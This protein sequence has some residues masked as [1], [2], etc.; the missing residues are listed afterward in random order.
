[1]NNKI[2]INFIQK[3]TLFVF[4]FLY[5]FFLLA[6]EPNHVFYTNPKA[7]SEYNSI[8]TNIHFSLSAPVVDENM[9][10]KFKITN[11][12]NEQIFF[13]SYVFYYGKFLVL[14]PLTKLPNHQKIKVA[15]T[16]K[17][18][19]SGGLWVDP[20][21]YTFTTNT[22]DSFE[23]IRMKVLA[24]D[25]SAAANLRPFV[26]ESKQA[27]YT[28]TSTIPDETPM[29][30]V[31]KKTNP[32]P[33]QIMLTTLTTSGTQQTN[34]LLIVD[35]DG[36]K[37]FSK[38]LPDWVL[39]FKKLSDSTYS[40]FN[41]Y[42]LCYYI[43]DKYLN[44]IDTVRAQNGYITDSRE[45]IVDRFGN[46]YIL[47][48]QYTVVDMSTQVSGGNPQA[49]VMGVVV[50]KLDRAKN[51]LFEWKSL[52]YLPILQAVGVSFTAN[53][54]D[55]LHSNSIEIDGDSAILLS[56]RHFNEIEKIN[57]YT[58]Q[59]IWR[60]GRNAGN[61]FSFPNDL[62]AFSYQHDAR[63]LPNGNIMLF[64]NG[65]Y[66]P[67]AR[68]SRVVEYKVDEVNKIA[69]KVW[70]YRHNPDITSNFMG[71]AQRLPNGNTMIGWGGT[72]PTLSEI[73]TNGNVVLEMQLPGG[74]F[75]YRALKF[76]L[77]KLLADNEPKSSLNDTSFFCNQNEATITG[78]LPFYLRNQTP[79]DSIAEINLKGDNTV[80]MVFVTPQNFFRYDSTQLL[81]NTSRLLQ[82]DTLL[83]TP[84]AL[85]LAVSN[86]CPEAK[87]RWSTNDSVPQI[88]ASPTK[89][90]YYWVDIRS[91]SFV[92]R[93]SVKVSV[94]DN[95][96]FDIYGVSVLKTPYEIHTYSVPFV[97]LYN[98]DWEV[99]NG[100]IVSG[101]GTNAVEIQWGNM[102]TGYINISMSR[103]V[104]EKTNK[105]IVLLNQITT[106]VSKVTQTRVKAYPNPAYQQLMV[107]AKGNFVAEV[108]SIVGRK[109]MVKQATDTGILDLTA[110]PEGIYT[111][112]VTCEGRTDLVRITKR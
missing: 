25:K 70:E 34:Y 14:D 102:D 93:D 67:T 101:F 61:Q 9:Q 63:R 7:G 80:E 28:T 110:L 30:I 53:F 100:N 55:Y 13:K 68:Y 46:Y 109:V 6:G 47:A 97:P 27:I 5:P 15:L 38:S 35:N 50:Q 10:G 29:V 42:D 57:T 31:G 90:S 89:D 60:M 52:D 74:Y 26:L 56:S 11:E 19:L 76:D 71:N 104:C 62:G 43:L 72:V 66:R 111:V 20:F 84:S 81:F 23:N 12:Q 58:G 99:V 44:P 3:L 95:K 92:I 4:L 82:R 98:Y 79:F 91:G 73:D 64:D 37:L 106:G 108:Y 78:N 77:S 88:Q 22:S 8:Y 75:S 36:R 59:V 65:N 17:L 87:Y 33:G 105:T 48:D 32:S 103:Q 24:G 86:G 41:N 1:M 21:S 69:T 112:L 94:A 18:Q 54:I 83:C 2:S 16:E 85:T 49:L 51:V 39:G 40:Y 45:L 107:E 96:P